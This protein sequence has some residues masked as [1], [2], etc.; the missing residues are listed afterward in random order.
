MRK[1]TQDNNCCYRGNLLAVKISD[2]TGVV[3]GLI[4]LY[5]HDGEVTLIRNPDTIRI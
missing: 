1:L 3:S 2:D 4:P 5:A